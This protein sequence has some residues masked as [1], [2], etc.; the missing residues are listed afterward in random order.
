ML[1]SYWP[2]LKQIDQCIRKEAEELASHV[3]LAVHEPMI[4]NKLNISNNTSEKFKVNAEDALLEHLLHSERP[5]PILGDAG[6]GK[7]HL[8]RWID[9]R[10]ATDPRTKDWLVRRIPKSSSLRQVLEILLGDLEGEF[11]DNVRTKIKDVG[12]RLN[13]REVADHLIVFMAHRLELLK[14]DND[15]QISE[16]KTSGQVPELEFHQRAGLIKRH[17]KLAGLPALLGDPN[18]KELLIGKGGCLYQIALRLTSGSN[19]DELA[20][21]DYKLHAKDLELSEINL[22]DLSLNARNYLK[23]SCLHTMMDRRQEAADLLNEVLSDACRRAFQHLFQLNGGDFQELFTEIR[24]HLMGKTLVILVEDM[25]AIT[26]IENDLIDSLLREGIRDGKEELC[27]V[28]SAIAVT[29]GYEGYKK[30][31]D[32]IATRSGSFEW[33]IEKSFDD[34]AFIFNRVENFC[35]RYLNAARHG[36]QQLHLTIPADRNVNNW[37]TIWHSEDEEEQQRVEAFEFSSK[38]YPLFPFNKAAL[39][40]LT[41]KYCRNEHQQ[42]GFNPRTIL[43]HLLIANL[44]TYRPCFENGQFPPLGLTDINCP[45]TLEGDLRLAVHK[46]LDRCLTLASIWGYGCRNIG[47]LAAELPSEVARVFKLEQLADALD[48]TLPL[49]KSKKVQTNP[50][51]KPEPSINPTSGASNQK[52]SVEIEQF[53]RV[54]EIAMEVDTW[55][56]N[57]AIEQGPAKILRK[58]LLEIINSYKKHYLKWE[59]AKLLPELQSGNRVLIHIPYNAN[60]PTKAHAS[61][62]SEKEFKNDALPYKAFLTAVLRRHELKSWNY[63]DGYRDYCRYQNFVSNWVAG[64]IAKMLEEQRQQLK[65]ILVKHLQ[66]A[67]V[68]NPGLSVASTKKR[69]DYLCQSQ[70]HI[71]DSFNKTGIERWDQYRDKVLGRWQNQQD[72]WLNLFSIN[73]HA[74]EGDLVVKVMRGANS[75]DITSETKKVAQDVSRQLAQDYRAFVLLDGCTTKDLFTELLKKL[76]KLIDDLSSHSQYLD[77]EQNITAKQLKNRVNKLMDGEHWK[78]VKSVLAMLAPFEAKAIINAINDFDAELANAVLEVL[79]T[80]TTLYNNNI[81]RMQV[82]NQ[83]SGSD[84]RKDVQLRITEALKNIETN[85]NTL[86]EAPL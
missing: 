86:S 54:T 69:L 35:G 38:G 6:S 7:S 83:E 20:R 84:K 12:E 61:F 10:L 47:E 22:G 21:N 65:P 17:V 37:P 55:F 67:S 43:G 68:V 9:M 76:L 14:Q 53:D 25:A 73:N 28:R 1:S 59:S 13:T 44:Q 33:H 41:D 4:L 36:S 30:R 75:E 64:V 58:A 77:M 19:D 15:K 11:F 85:L 26:A 2:N 42:L 16:I 48:S 34:E 24:K 81:G 60:N 70:Q 32:T 62:G 45:G 80:W 46:D 72:Q 5:I 27:V 82:I 31:R 29:T 79:N 78:T 50:V 74:L 57:K 40:A 39:R 66:D 51:L 23:S 71:Q 3:L 63:P 52:S 49:A 56:A 18:F 8:V